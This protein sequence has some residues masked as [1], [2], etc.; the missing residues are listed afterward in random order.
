MQRELEDQF[1]HL[2]T[3]EMQCTLCSKQLGN[4]I[5]SKVWSHIGVTHDKTNEILASKGIPP[6]AVNIRGS[7]ISK[8][9]ASDVFPEEV[10]PRFETGFTGA[11]QQPILA[12]PTPSAVAGELAAAWRDGSGSW[13]GGAFQRHPV[14]W[15]YL[16]F[17]FKV[18]EGTTA[19]ASVVK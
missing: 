18:E 16:N 8:R 7:K 11:L 13:G 12:T 2:L 17:N 5:K 9:K 10:S 3:E 15:F 6:I 1:G 14:L 19:A 4:Y